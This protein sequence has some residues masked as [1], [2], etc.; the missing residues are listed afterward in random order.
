MEPRFA[1]LLV[2]GG[3]VSREQLSEAQKK[4]KESGSSVT[5]ELVRLGFTDEDALT[6]FLAKQFGIE[7]IELVPGEI[8]DSVFSLV[9]PQIVQKHQLIPYKLLGSTLTVVVSDPTDLV[10]INEVK[11]VTGYGVR[12]A[13]ATPA[14]IKKTLEHRFGGV[15][16]DDVLK[17]FGDGEMEVVQESDDVSLQE[18]QQATMDA[19]VVTLVNA[20]LADAA[21]R[22][23]SDIHVE[24]YE[25]IFRVR[26]RIDGVLQEIMNPPLRLKNALVSR[27][28]VMAGLDIAERRLTQDGRIKLK[29]GVGGELDIRVSIL[30]TLFGEKVVMRLLD[31]SNLQL[32]M[33]KL[34]FDPQNLKDFQE[35]IH[36]PYGMILI[37]GP[38]GSGKST[39]LYSGL[40]ELN[41]PDVNISTAEDPVE[42]NL[43]GIN[44]VQVRDQIGL[45]FAACLRSFLRQDPDIIMVGEIR[46]LETAQ[47][48]IKASLTGHLVLST[49]HTND[50]PATVDRLLNM[51]V[52]PFLLTSS[53]N[54]IL[55]Q[56]LVRKICDKCKEPA[57]I[58]PE[59][60]SNLGVDAADI[61][62]GFPAFQGRGCNNCGGTGY[63]GRLAVYEVMVMH[64]SLKEM[65]LKSA[66][67]M[68]LKREA[69][70]LGMSSLRMSALQKVRDGLTT[71]DETI[72]VTDTDKGFGSVFS[73]GF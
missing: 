51:G 57:E 49:L 33:S 17:R 73:L 50:C 29:M 64:E 35:A 46:D 34:G 13:M 71:V 40:S 23:C 43:V 12:L 70:K 37:T 25:K 24:P 11:F 41:K 26:F 38:T 4:E 31:K 19:P 21:K 36:K 30:P 58:K 10:A 45:N 3:I 67:A 60:L 14:N 62:A 56:R 53:I 22:R 16:Y 39:T 27:L 63:R 69:V 32:D 9:P 61:G 55:A 28:K 18:L 44:Q 66:S 2:K 65:I 8:E 54:L 72:R 42:Y 48:A 1:E 5:K 47:I 20:I 6:N 7:I 15:S 59:V 68:E 52:E